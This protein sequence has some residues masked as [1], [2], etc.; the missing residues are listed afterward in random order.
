MTSSDLIEVLAEI[1][2][3]GSAKVLR[4]IFQ[5]SNNHPKA[6]HGLS[7]LVDLEIIHITRSTFL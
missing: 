3:T 6:A 5:D 2:K 4:S 7:L 1:G